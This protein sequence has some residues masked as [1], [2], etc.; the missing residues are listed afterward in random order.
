MVLVE[1]MQQV[2]VE[3]KNSWHVIKYE[4]MVEHPVQI[5]LE[6]CQFLNLNTVTHRKLKSGLK[7]LV[8][9]DSSS[10]N[11]PQQLSKTARSRPC[12]LWP[13]WPLKQDKQLELHSEKRKAKR[14]TT[15]ITPDIR[16]L[17]NVILHYS[18]LPRIEDFDA[19]FEASSV[20]DY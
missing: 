14:H 19:L 4:H 15:V 2:R 5:M 17:I 16:A 11:Q 20:A 18:N 13:W 3:I 9:A 1:F 7:A 10:T 6:T 12:I 8:R